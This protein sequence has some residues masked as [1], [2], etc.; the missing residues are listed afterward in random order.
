MRGW[1]GFGEDG[2]D[3][4]GIVLRCTRIYEDTKST[5]MYEEIYDRA[6]RF[7]HYCLESMVQVYVTLLVSSGS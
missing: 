6:G 5:K 4:T 2:E 7:R 3:L 1:C